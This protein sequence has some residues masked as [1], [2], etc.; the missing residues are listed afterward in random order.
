M[1]D[2]ELTT[3]VSRVLTSLQTNSKT[4]EDLTPVTSLSD[5][6]VFEIGGGKKVTYKVLRDLI[7]SMS[8]ADQDSLKTL[9]NKCEL[10]SVSITTTESTATLTV[11]SVGKSISTSI[12]IATTS[13]AGLMS[14]ADKLRLQ[15][16]YD[17]ANTAKTTADNA[18]RTATTANSNATSA[19]N[20]LNKITPIVNGV[21]ILPFVR[22]TYHPTEANDLPVG[23]V[24]YGADNHYFY[25]KSGDSW[26][27][28]TD[29]NT[30][31]EHGT[32]IPRP[33]YI[34]RCGNT[35]Y[36]PRKVDWGDYYVLDAYVIGSEKFD[37]IMATVYGIAIY[38]FDGIVETC[39]ESIDEGKIIYVKEDKTFLST[40]DGVMGV[41]NAYC[42]ANSNPRTDCLFR[43]DNQ[44][45][46]WDGSNFKLLGEDPETV[47]KVNKSLLQISSMGIV[48]VQGTMPTKT[49][50]ARPLY[51]VWMWGSTFYAASYNN[52][53]SREDY[54]DTNNTP[55][56]DRIFRNSTDLYKFDGKTFVKIGG[57]SATGNCYNV[58][59]E[60]P[61]ENGDFYNLESAILAALDAGVASTGMQIT[62]AI[63][64]GSWKTFQYVG[65]NITDTNFKNTANWIDSAGM[66]AGTEPLINVNKLCGDKEYTLETALE[67]LIAKETSTG[68]GYRKEGLILTYLRDR[69]SGTWETKQYHGTI[70]DM[71]PKNSGLWHDFGG[72]GSDVEATDKIVPSTDPDADKAVKSSAVYDALQKTPIV[73]YEEVPD[74]DNVVWQGINAQ[75]NA[76][77]SPIKIP[78][79]TGQG[80]QSGTILTIYPESQAVWGA[81]G[82]NIVL[83]AAIKSVSYDGDSE[84]LGTIR[85]I[86][87]LDALTRIELWS[88][89][90]NA[91]SSTSA[92]DLKFEYPFTDF[93]TEAAAKDFYIEAT[94]ADGNRK[95]KLITVTAVDVTCTV[96]A[97]L[98]YTAE[99][100]LTVGGPSM[101][102][103][104]YKFENNVSTKQG[105]LVTTEMLF[106]GEWKVLGLATI[107]DSYSHNI[108]IDPNNV[109]GGGEK[110][111]HGSYP[112][113]ISGK[114]IASGVVGNTVYS[115]VMCIDSK[116]KIPVISLQYDDRNNGKI[117]LYDSLKVEV[118][119]YVPGEI[120][121]PI[122]VVM[123][124]MPILATNCDSG[125]SVTVSKQIQ[126]YASDGS[127]HFDVYAQNGRVKSHTIT[128]TVEG[129]AI[130]VQVKE[131][132]LYDFD[133]STR[134]N[135]ESDHSIV[136][137]GYQMTLEGC[138]YNSN[139]F[140]TRLG[141]TVCR[142]AEN[143]SGEIHHAPF[144]SAALETSGAA[145]QLAF[146]TNSIKDKD[147]KLCECYDP[148][149]GVGFYIT[150]NEIVLASLNGEPKRQ[151][152]RF[153]CGEK[154]TVAVV[155]EPGTKYVTAKESG[156]N[157]SFVKL[158][159]NGEEA[160]ALGYIPGT[161]ALRQNKTITFNSESGDF[162]LNYF[163]A[164][165]SYMGWL[166][167]FNNYLCRLSD[168]NAMIEEYDRENVLDSTGKPSMAM[169][170]AHGIPYYV[171]VAD[172]TT[173]NNFD[174]ALNGGTS[175]GDVFSCNLYY[176]NPE[177]PEVNF[178]A[179]NVYWRRQGTTS[180]QRPIKNDRFNFNKKFKTGPLT[181]QKATVTLLNPDESTEL[182]RKAIKAVKHNKVY[183]SETGHFIDVVTVKV[184]YSDSSMAN[185][186]G[187][188]DMMNA[189]F[190][191]L[192]S[193]FMTPAQRAFDGTQ[194]LGGGDVLTGIQMDH[195]TKNHPIAV[196]RATTDTLQDAWF[197]AR[198]NWKEDKGE[199]VAL[200]FK[201]TPGYNLG[202]LNYGDFVEYFG[203]K[204]ETLA[205]TEARFKK[206]ADVNTGKVY[207]ISQYC[208]RDYAIYRHK[209]GSWVR[210]T[211][212]MRQVN[213]K[214]VVTGDVLNPVSGYELLQ[215]QGMDWWQGVTTVEDM[216]APSTQI[217]SWVQKLGLGQSTYPA[218]TFYFECMI[219]DDQ[220]QE[221]LALGKKVPYDLFNM[222]RFFDS[223][224]Y[225]K[226]TGWEKIWRENAYKYMSMESGMAYTAFTDFLAAVDQRAKNMQPM[227]F[228]EDGCSVENGV[229]VGYKG[230]E[231][232]RMYL[233]K[234]YDCDTCNGAD[235]DGGR[236]ID[237]EVDPNKQ[238]DEATGY[239]N[240]Y[241]GRGSVL[242]NNMD[243]CP[244]VWNSN[245]LGA[246]TISLAKTVQTMRTRTTT[247]DGKTMS[248]F[249]PE[250]AMYFFVEKRLKF[251][252]KVVTSYDCERKY[253]D[254]TNIANKLY[255]YALHG[256]GL[257]ALPRFIEQRWGIRDG[258][259]QAG[260][261]FTNP[262]TIRMA[263]LSANSKITITAQQTSYFG[264]GNDAGQTTSECVKIEAGETHEFTQFDHG[265]AEIRIYQPARIRM[266][267]LSEMS[268]ATGDFSACS[269]CEELILGG[270]KHT[271]NP[272]TGFGNMSGVTL[273]DMPFL[274][275]LDVSHTTA[276]SI[277]ANG[278]PRMESINAD[279]TSL[280]K[281]DLAQ[282]APIESLVLPSTMTE[283][284]FV[285]LPKLTYPGGLQ[286]TGV[287]NVTRLWIEGS[288]YIDT[289]SLL[290]DVAQGGN[291]KYVR[292]P[293]VN[294]TASV[295]VLRM[296]KDS[297]A[298]G[299]DA[300]GDDYNEPGK[301]SGVLGRWILTELIEDR[302]VDGLAGMNSLKAYFPQLTIFNS[303]FSHIC[304]SDFESDTENI[305]NMD[306]STGYKF[307]T[308]YTV[309][310]HWAKVEALSKVYK[311]TYNSR[312]GKMY[313]KRISDADYTKMA[314][315]TDYD[316]TDQSGEGFDVMK[317]IYPHWRK[318][319]NDYK[320]QEK[321]TF[322]SSCVDEPISTA[323]KVNRA[324]LSDILVKGLAAIFTDTL[325]AGG[326]FEITDNP[327]MNVY[328]ID[329]DGMKQVRW[330]G[331]NNATVGA[332]F[333]DADGKVVGKY[334]MM[335]SN[336]Q[337]D[338]IPGEYIYTDVPTGAVRF[339]FTAP[340]GHDDKEA[341]A[342]DSSAV[343]AIEPDWVY[344]G[345]DLE[346]KE[347]AELC[348]VYGMSLDALM[349]ARSISGQVTKR[350]DGT[351]TI[352]GEW[353]YDNEG[354][355]TNATVPTST[356]HYCAADLINLC[357]MRGPGFYS[358]D[359]EMR[360]DIDNIVM[361]L[362]GDRDVQAVCGYGCG[363][364]YTTGAN[365]MNTYGNV[366]RRWNG[367]NTGNIIFGIQNYVGCNSEWQ[368]NVAVNVTS[369]VEMRRKKYAEDSSF[370]IDAKWHIYN[371]I[372]KT[373][374]VV[375][376]I[377]DTNGSCVA[378]VRHGRYCDMIASR[379]T[380]DTSKYNQNYADGHWYSAGRSRVPLRSGSNANAYGG[381]ACSHAYHAGTS[382]NTLSGVRLA[383]RGACVFDD[384]A[385]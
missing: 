236:D 342:V 168:V 365:N 379:C 89:T 231:P 225:S 202:C 9:V 10:K 339:Y 195:S 61:L 117:R 35:L 75:G 107:T 384:E 319:V 79:G 312:D 228:L 162:N 206:D 165:N 311:A 295:K 72:G 38:P 134:S 211:G 218:W 161:N 351:S 270:V 71:V 137:K 241:M 234:V 130:D 57:S 212:S 198:G 23:S 193:T 309:P 22:Q 135:N 314:D 321:H 182:G 248:P 101:S 59:N 2:S 325:Y 51:G 52:G 50:S 138:N 19:I 375:Q 318:G 382:S 85:T 100:A 296:I 151:S 366:T 385:A 277:D 249:S 378:R 143:V 281:C 220:L 175:T 304:F 156:R 103:P 274:R 148:A 124:G 307:G 269:M 53:F 209:N 363:A 217:S 259:Y 150:G 287:G 308:P 369:F 152:V 333:V 348:A 289:E 69:D 254:N 180:A 305:T 98:G 189:T 224:D 18:S 294:M 377:T 64:P 24:V 370:P 356:I 3:I 82:E 315:G 178:K 28:A 213:G 250:G 238:T 273:G 105:I 374:R 70:T 251:W 340:T 232:L 367:G 343:E 155:V 183:C 347:I 29:Y 110:L 74:P 21:K 154:V 47:A 159:V 313:C 322:I 160:A 45:Y 286:L 345:G 335:V 208:G 282:T 328:A 129:S 299:I 164:Y 44:L 181:G 336:G 122:E 111:T 354:N 106:G 230:M 337:F 210:S 258:Y 235:N 291:L 5:T 37:E 169:M 116:S 320:T 115:A 141:E 188:C 34:F 179:V 121:V 146:S 27:N 55:R 33:D 275:V 371:P 346:N 237:P 326:D 285:N 128:L 332:V 170:A 216:M 139:G 264:I 310:G 149:S 131:G 327:N 302:D 6:D 43:L 60:Q 372:T 186:C 349:R 26:V 62:F 272:S 199:Q 88:N 40:K 83:R 246:T 278:C 227:F 205:Q 200:G 233:N 48:P 184:D 226:V 203:T 102:L 380:T 4:I 136:S 17:T 279:G 303:Q 46:R 20:Q 300:S 76:V 140:V 109:F 132:A 49:G 171:I 112:L 331:V 268:L 368:D 187:V 204:G 97:K 219:D 201:D 247:I 283:L 185:D 324:K 158:Y 344:I 239:E 147:A 31:D 14:A 253:I 30:T 197:H 95:E 293:G 119:A 350:G 66:T 358:I 306:D 373:E 80:Q 13:K 252:P 194:D 301:C 362:I 54:F 127:K 288:K 68:I 298:Q 93:I 214:W 144:S 42:I 174:Y 8:S 153:K 32:I 123:D 91:S 261:F 84:V 316:P 221:D 108:S 280:Q 86:R 341:I 292:I 317:R 113:R 67:A 338:F 229:Y 243:R 267:D 92:N 173:F 177:H 15:S 353:A 157:Y 90:V 96:I 190:R 276:T 360:V 36:A 25:M 114:D 99:T 364:G 120:T 167:A 133:F 262:L 81:F 352:N 87:I 196:F 207:L 41:Y 94:D 265:Q 172:Q 125:K 142:I 12:P 63:A 359:Y 255:F 245:D 355:L 271:S 376:G 1:T 118:A 222:L 256:S 215:Y 11:S 244:V 260:D 284:A 334:N 56:K 263:A 257:T 77:G 290:L 223:C 126:G 266:L 191:A 323:T 78:K 240:P 357:R 145:V 65:V 383:F 16:A 192:G 104:M 7:A 166:E 297:G 73:D 242:F 163:I 330:P 361:G 329:V 58:T 176:Y 39:P 381:L